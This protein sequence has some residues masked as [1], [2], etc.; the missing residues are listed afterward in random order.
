MKPSITYLV[1]ILSAAAQTSNSQVTQR[2]PTSPLVRLVQV[3]PTVQLE[4]VDWGGH[5][6]P[7][8]FLA[9]S[10][11]T[12]HVFDEFAPQF[13]DRFHVLGITRRGYGGSSGVLPPNDVDTLVLDIRSVLDSL[14]F[15]GVVLVGHSFAGEELT[16]FAELN[17]ARCTGLISLDAAYD[18]TGIPAIVK[19]NPPPAPPPM[20]AADSASPEALRGY[21][22]RTFASPVPISEIL[23]TSRFDP[24]S[25]RLIGSVTAD[26]LEG[27]LMGASKTPR[28][29]RVQCRSLA[30]YNVPESPVDFTPYYPQLDSAG[31]AQA[32]AFFR[33]ATGLVVKSETLFRQ[34][35]RNE[36]VE[37][38]HSKHY[39]FLDRPTEVARAIRRFLSTA[40]VN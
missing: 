29:D 10:G 27:R 5:G 36:V 22:A 3:A 6:R 34:S 20:T 18:R 2:K 38:H 8:V 33:A 16:R 39:V 21:L 30:I 31:R 24:S 35:G 9:G 26:S 14:R 23:A 17:P 11:D 12:P 37:L 19:A 1:V 28:Y 7:V 15:A 4:V 32:D 25:G 13:T 40:Q